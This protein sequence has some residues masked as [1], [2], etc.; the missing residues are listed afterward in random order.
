MFQ[1]ST[2]GRGQGSWAS[3]L[4]GGIMEKR[5][6][7][8]KRLMKTTAWVTMTQMVVAL[9]APAMFLAPLPTYA[10]SDGYGNPVI[11]AYYANGN[12]V[13]PPFDCQLNPLFN[14]V[15]IVGTGTV[16]K[17]LGNSS[18]NHGIQIDWNG[19][20][21]FEDN[22]D[23]DPTLVTYSP[24]DTD[25]DFTYAFTGTHTYTGNQQTTIA[26][27][28][29]HGPPSGND[30]G[31]AETFTIQVCPNPQAPAQLTVI[32]DVVNDSGTGQLSEFTIKVDDND[33]DLNDLLS[34][35]Y[36]DNEQ[37]T[38]Q[39]ASGTYTV[40][41]QA[42]ANYNATISCVGPGGTTAGT[43]TLGAGQ[44]ATCTVTND[45]IPAPGTIIIQKQT[46]PDGDQQVFSFTGDITDSAADNGSFQ[47][48]LAAGTYTVTESAQSGWDLTDLQCNDNDSTENVN[49][50]TASINLAAGETV[51]CVFTNTKRGSIIVEKQTTPNADGASFSF[52]GDA[53]GS[54]TDGQQI[55]VGSLI[56][57]TYTSTESALAGWS[58]DSIVCND[59]NS[60]GDLNTRTATF[61]VE[62][63]ETVKCTFNNTKLG[64]IAV[65]K[66]AEPNGT[67]T[68][69][70]TG[71]ESDSFTLS[72]GGSDS[73]TDLTPGAYSLA[74]VVPEGWE[75]NQAYAC[76]KGN[77]S[78]DPSNISLGAG[79]QVNCIYLNGDVNAISGS[80]FDDLEADG[81]KDNTD[82]GLA[83]WTIQVWSGETLVTSA[84]TDNSGNYSIPGLLEGSYTVC[85]SL[86][87][88]WMQ[89]LPSS[90][91]A[92]PGETYGYSVTVE[93]GGIYGGK[94]FG[95]YQNGSISGTKYED[96]NGNGI[97]DEDWS[98]LSNWTIQLYEVGGQSPVDSTITDENGNY[99]FT[100][101]APGTYV[102]REVL[103]SDWSAVAPEVSVGHEVVVTSGDADGN[104]DFV[105]FAD[106]VVSGYKFEDE[107]GDGNWDEG[108]DPIMGW[109]ITA[110]QGETE[111]TTTTD[112]NGYY[113]FTFSLA[114]LGSWIISEEHP[115]GWLQTM[116]ESGT[117]SF[118]VTS[119]AEASD[120]D[121]GNTQVTSITVHKFY[122]YNENGKYGEGEEPL[123]GWEFCLHE[124]T[125]DEDLIVGDEISCLETG[126]DGEATWAGDLAPGS[127]AVVETEQDGWH[128][129]T[130]GLEE[131]VFVSSGQNATVHFGNAPDVSIVGNKWED[132]NGNGEWDE[133]PTLAGWT[134]ALAK[135][136]GDNT[137]VEIIWIGQTDGSGEFHLPVVA[138]GQYMVFEE[139]RDGALNTYPGPSST[140][141]NNFTGLDL[142]S[143]V[144][145]GDSFFDITV[146]EGA[147]GAITVD[148]QERN[149]DF[150]NFIGTTIRG[151]KWSDANG[152]GE[153]DENEEG[154]ADWPIAL[155]IQGE[156][157]PQEGEG[158][159]P[160]PV[161]I[162]ALQLTG[163]DG[164]FGFPILESGPYVI[165]EKKQ[166][167]WE[168]TYPTALGELI[169]VSP[170]GDHYYTDSFFDVFVS[171]GDIEDESTI[172]QVQVG[173]EEFIDI[174]FGNHYLGDQDGDGIP[175]PDDNC[176][177]TPNPDQADSDNDGIGDAC[178]QPAPPPPSGGGGGGGAGGGC[179]FIDP[180]ACN[181][182]PVTTSGGTSGTPPPTDGG[183]AGTP[184]PT[185]GGTTPPG[186]VAGEQTES[187]TGTG[188]STGGTQ[189]GGGTQ[190]AGGQVLGEADELLAQAPAETPEETPTPTEEPAPESASAPTGGACYLILGICWYWWLLIILVVAMLLW[191]WAYNKQ[192]KNQK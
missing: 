67:F 30:S 56:P 47:R 40:S 79:E 130:G 155:G 21:V 117:Y 168:K 108:E 57:G 25:K 10:A 177:N 11:T 33:Q 160:I 43:V 157:G 96:E 82:P 145:D 103:Q 150:G 60:S 129:T 5:S 139:D 182:N 144:L 165:L 76:T 55:T 142:G 135:A 183:G 63:G 120:Y 16:T 37:V 38:Y 18:S 39:L 172:T 32:K 169:E 147:E 173:E 124:A 9:V 27:Q 188:G 123:A 163:G 164:S 99:S 97:D 175:D 66:Y 41:E 68:F 106:A 2:R 132:Q 185:D 42:Y 127:Y 148:D 48:S 181:N 140:Y 114:D 105:N 62:A 180:S 12:Q 8:G 50:R 53:A 158:P 153:W 126:E 93:N 58:L 102:V 137:P 119:G 131:Y 115:S 178:D 88:G 154:L 113:E 36:S 107:N 22:S 51:T 179:G 24:D 54:I 28:I 69:N 3:R 189:S 78:V 14:P 15:T 191:W 109:H 6:R 112:E 75:G 94:D 46:L 4:V 174:I 31:L 7:I 90:G 65:T 70:L 141:Y 101:L 29:Y 186:E 71:T 156:I 146:G 192:K 80:K 116:P 121:F 91:T 45:D 128:V 26:V 184:P 159:F 171:G 17:A 122:D 1:A 166:D 98:T 49:T 187:G 111:V 100:D 190:E 136:A 23:D 89:S 133:E 61:N 72:N 59:Q 87:Q 95:N 84:V 125:Y 110:T 170:N 149:I 138:S 143:I 20:G 134:V 152:D 167:I 13:F 176:V 83:G 52:T 85:E 104:N 86:Q 77:S 64:V 34:N 73:F 74:E 162:V 19:D 161:E 151:F 81:D 44:S 118:D 35:N 92:C